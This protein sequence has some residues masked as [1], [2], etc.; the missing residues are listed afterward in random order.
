MS[1]AVF[2]TDA[3][4]SRMLLLEAVRCGLHE[5]EP[6]RASVWLLDLDHLPAMKKTP[7]PAIQIGFS[8]HPEAV[9]QTTARALYALLPLPFSARE[10]AALLRHRELPRTTLMQDGEALWLG[11]KKLH[12]SKAEQRVL[13]LLCENRDRVV[14]LEEISCVLGE[15]AENSNATAVYLYRLRR[16]LEADGTM[17]IRTVRGVGYQW[18]G[19]ERS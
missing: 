18:M 16:K 5:I 19:D 4:L 2:S 8:A 11:G 12:F 6:A 15:R 7:H 1:V 17:R 3:V 13:S 14:T 10:L 9:L